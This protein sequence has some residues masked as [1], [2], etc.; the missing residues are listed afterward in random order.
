[1]TRRFYYCNNQVTG[2]LC[3]DFTE[4]IG[5]TAGPFLPPF[6]YFETGYWLM[7]AKNGTTS[8]TGWS[9]YNFITGLQKLS[10]EQFQIIPN[11][12]IDHLQ[13][14]RLKEGTEVKIYN[15]TGLIVKES[16]Y[17]NSGLELDD[18]VSGMY[19]LMVRQKDGI[20]T[21]AGRF[22]KM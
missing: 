13:I 1:M 12:A 22:L 8:L 5:G 17:Y 6:Y 16:I 4:G 20:W 11:P 10:S 19:Y 21:P 2:N 3:G 18:F 15:S 14:K 7:C 9:C